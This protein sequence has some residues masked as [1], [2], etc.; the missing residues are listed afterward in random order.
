MAKLIELRS[1]NASDC[2]NSGFYGKELS[3]QTVFNKYLNNERLDADAIIS[4]TLHSNGT[5][6]M[7]YKKEIDV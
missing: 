2:K 4:I 3:D 5:R 6:I 1:V 7:W